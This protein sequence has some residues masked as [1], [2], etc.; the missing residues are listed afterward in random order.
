[1]VALAER[2]TV[3]RD[4]VRMT[5]A[6]RTTIPALSGPIVRRRR[7]LD[8]LSDAVTR[9]LTLVAAPA[10][11]GKTVL[12]AAW[13]RERGSGLRIAWAALDGT[14]LDR[15]GFWR[16]VTEAVARSS[17]RPAPPPP[18]SGDAAFHAFVVEAV[19]DDVPLLVVLDDF[20]DVADDAVAGDLDDLL[21]HPAAVLRIMLLT[22]RDPRLR[23]SRLRLAG[24][25][26][27]IRADALAFTEEEAMELLGASDAELGPAQV[28]TLWR[29]T[30]GWAA[31]LRLAELSLRSHPDPDAF[32]RAFDGNDAAVTD[33]L[34]TEV[35]SRQSASGRRFLLRTSIADP[36]CGGLADA[37]T[38]HGDGDRVLRRFAHGNALLTP[39]D[40]S[41]T[42]W[43]YH[44]LFRDLLTAEL[45]YAY[46][47]EIPGL[48]REAARW[49]A[50]H[51]HLDAAMGHALAADDVELA[52]RT[53]ADTWIELLLEQSLTVTA[54]LADRL[55][56]SAFERHPGLTLAVATVRLTEGRLALADEALARAHAQLKTVRPQRRNRYVAE[57]AFVLL[58][59]ARLF[60]G[61]RQA[62]A[63]T[64]ALLDGEDLAERP[65]DALHV[66]LRA[67]LGIAELWSGESDRALADL[68]WASSAAEQL[69]VDY[70][71]ALATAHQ[72]I[73]D[74]LTGAM[75][76]G[77]IRARCAAEILERRGWTVT[78]AAAAAYAARGA[79]ELARDELAAAQ[80]T[81]ER[82]MLAARGTCDLSVRVYNSI[83]HARLLE[84]LGKPDVA[85]ASLRLDLAQVPPVRGAGL[86]A[87]LGAVEAL[88]Q[89]EVGERTLA[90]KRLEELVATT[91]S[92]EAR[93][94]LA[95][96]RLIAGRPDESLELVKSAEPVPAHGT[97]VQSLGV[98]ALA[99][100][101]LVDH[102]GAAAALERALDLAEPSGLRRPL[103]E[104]GNALR[105]VLRRQLRGQ[106]AHG[107]LVRELLESY[108]RPRPPQKRA[109]LLREPLSDRELA[110]L[111]Y[112]PT[113]MTNQEIAGELFISVNTLKTHLRQIY[114]KLG[115][116]RRR[117]AVERARELQLVAPRR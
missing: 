46:E 78:A 49:L 112:L 111:R 32:V 19:A 26:A 13:A 41:G 47:A 48:H 98:E 81:M 59:R 86:G 62:L 75:A 56:P 35:L 106:T 76:E 6:A 60:G 53:L 30:E 93:L 108:D 116:T 52:A 8:A 70:V 105:P 104:L 23:L 63:E 90:T 91:D 2:A 61:L 97:A 107:G 40:A 71:A 34:L 12:A 18:A 80:A 109:E 100:D 99:R 117:D 85:L 10:G 3:S 82:A 55:P 15:R 69:G 89:F 27:E 95:R 115:V 37:L 42:W 74:V 39:A 43:R 87:L 114:R 45:R 92:D 67:S 96:V 4:G 64:R 72:A 20:Q 83:S 22:R 9:P 11:T 88:L 16:L 33:Y 17:G 79:V 58:R 102:A 57:L 38:G 77:A 73:H 65:V 21:L 25:L 94:M 66:L 68:E 29:R 5:L 113:M 54:D 44:S 24:M 103:L 1:M 31:G 28:A 7:L 84:A 50:D 36:V 14:D 51:G 101:A 110:A